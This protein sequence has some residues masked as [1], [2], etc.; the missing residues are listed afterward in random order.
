GEPG[1]LPAPR[2]EAAAHGARARLRVAARGGER[3][4][5]AVH[6][7]GVPRVFDGLCPRARAA[8]VRDPLLPVP[9]PGRAPA[10]PRAELPVPARRPGRGVLP[11]GRYLAA[12]AL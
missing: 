6:G 12:R 8:A 2:G 5:R 4:E 11:P 10:D 1:A 3:V 9:R 7:K